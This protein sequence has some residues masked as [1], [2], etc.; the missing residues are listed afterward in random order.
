VVAFE[1]LE[2]SAVATT[3][4]AKDLHG[5]RSQ[6]LNVCQITRIDCPVVESDEDIAPESI[7]DTQN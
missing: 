1:L 4:S 3:L 2:R 6:V 7:L 5:G